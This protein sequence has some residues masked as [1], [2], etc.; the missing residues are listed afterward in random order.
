MIEII[1]NWHPIFVHF[2]VGLLLIAALFHIVVMLT[3]D[4]DLKQAFSHVANWNLWVGTAISLVTV[5]A[6]WFAYNSVN[7]DTPSHLAMIEHRN[8]ALVTFAVYLAVGLWSAMAAKKHAPIQWP[9]VIAVCV[10][11]GLLA[12]TAWHGGELVYRHGLGVMSLPNPDAHA[13][14]EGA[15]HNHDHGHDSASPSQSSGHAHD[16]G[17]E[18]SHAPEA[19]ATPQ[20]GDAEQ[21]S[22]MQAESASHSHDDGHSHSHD[23]DDMAAPEGEAAPEASSVESKP[24]APAE[25]T[26]THSH[27]PGHAHHEH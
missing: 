2:S 26:G 25:S 1:P 10:A 21:S 24:E 18:P 14:G 20:H 27:E 16:D 5:I 22:A 19:T 23:H 17:H 3:R 11:G 13:H 15:G 4:G 9:L 6:G 7:H 8:L 12:S